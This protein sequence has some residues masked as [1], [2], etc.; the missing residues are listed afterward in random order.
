MSD[1]SFATTPLYVVE[2]RLLDNARFHLYG[3][4]VISD[5]E[6]ATVLGTRPSTCD[7]RYSVVWY[8]HLSRKVLSEIKGSHGTLQCLP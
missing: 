2:K 5:L 7:W 4:C 6:T 8:T 3:A 1:M